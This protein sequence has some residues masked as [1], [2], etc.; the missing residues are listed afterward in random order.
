MTLE[1][2]YLNLQ[3]WLGPV[4]RAEHGGFGWVE[5]GLD[6]IYKNSSLV[7]PIRVN[8]LC[9]FVYT[10]MFDLKVPMPPPHLFHFSAL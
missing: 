9:L 3:N 4:S 5:H 6:I 10:R 7:F 1:L 2:K 8:G